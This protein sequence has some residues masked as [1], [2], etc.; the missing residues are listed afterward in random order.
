VR[1][2]VGHGIGREMHEEPKVPNYVDP[3]E[4]RLDFMLL[5]GMVIAVEPMVNIGTGAVVYADDSGW[6]VATKDGK[7]S[8]HFEHTIA[9]RD[10]GADVLT[11][12]R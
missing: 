11:D 9:V 10:H 8:A 4:R 3:R 5:P 6:P 12:G 7:C 1:E 2:F